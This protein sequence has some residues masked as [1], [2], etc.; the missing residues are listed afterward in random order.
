MLCFWRGLCKV[1][2]RRIG[3][4]TKPQ[5]GAR[6]LMFS[7]CPSHPEAQL[8]HG[9]PFPLQTLSPPA[10]ELGQTHSCQAVFRGGGG[11]QSYISLFPHPRAC[12]SPSGP[13]RSIP[14]WNRAAARRKPERMP[15]SGCT[16]TSL[17]EAAQGERKSTRANAQQITGYGSA[18]YAQARPWAAGWSHAAGRATQGLATPG[19]QQ[20]L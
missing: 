4:T 17:A 10:M 3:G 14:A 6:S 15:L 12:S 16:I 7:A 5:L 19:W 1:Y 20:P 18:A 11:R 9:A 13:V 2:Y 8:H